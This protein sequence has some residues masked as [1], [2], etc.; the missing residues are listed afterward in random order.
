MKKNYPSKNNFFSA[1]IFLVFTTLFFSN[2]LV[3]Q[4]GI[5][6]SDPDPSAIL[7]IESTDKGVLLPK[8]DLENLTDKN[9]VHNPTEGLLVYNKRDDN[10]RDLR[11]GFYI[12]DD[13][14]WDK[15]ENQSDIDDIMEEI[16]ERFNELEDGS[17]WTLN[18]NSLNGSE[19]LGSTNEQPI[20]FKVNNEKQAEFGIKDR[21]SIGRDAVSDAERSF[22]YGY[23][24]KSNGN[25]SYAYGRFSSVSGERTYAFGYQASSSGHDAYSF[26]REAMSSG[27]NSIAFGYQSLSSGKDSY[28]IGR[29]SSASREGSFAFGENSISEA[30][31]AI[32]IG[33]GAKA[34]QEYSLILGNTKNI[35]QSDA[36]KVGI[37]TNQPTARLHIDGSF[38][39]VDGSEG[40]N[41]VL[42]SDANGNAT[43]KSIGS[44]NDSGDAIYGSI[45]SNSG[46]T[47]NLSLRNGGSHEVDFGGGFYKNQM[48]TSNK[49][50]RTQVKG[51]YKVNYNI[52]MQKGTGNHLDLEIYIKTNG[53]KIH[54]TT[55]YISLDSNTNYRS[56][57]VEKIIEIEKDT[58]ISLEIK[59]ID[60]GNG[61]GNNK[62]FYQIN[63]GTSLN[64]EL[65]RRL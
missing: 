51:V 28:S 35:N 31:K 16:D 56:S 39:Y 5:G 43:W 21:I 11:K 32:S 38:R 33:Y 55:S 13:E 49:S 40:T 60:G 24:S 30:K 15:V 18:G 23:G 46:G 29:N 1:F 22:A 50:I 59:S 14:K 54:G 34:I 17:G 45:Y 62:D 37:G 42:T 65:I 9:T 63:D 26:G 10:S 48:Q 20:V 3:A 12:W 53:S 47:Q 64:V 19:F 61:N 25:D 6:T 44:G 4:V 27:D 52:T 41:K 8:V 58:D 36:T 2:S 57:S 7:H